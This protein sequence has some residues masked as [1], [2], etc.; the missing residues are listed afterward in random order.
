MAAAHWEQLAAQIQ[1]PGIREILL[2]G[3]KAVLQEVYVEPALEKLCKEIIALE[4]R[5]HDA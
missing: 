4:R 1:T 3:S 2:A 5:V